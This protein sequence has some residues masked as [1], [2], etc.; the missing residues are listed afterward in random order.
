MSQ[1]NGRVTGLNQDVFKALQQVKNPQQMSSAEAQKLKTAIL[2]DGKIDANE[3]DL[4]EELTA[5]QTQ[6]RVEA[7][8]ESNF[9]P[10]A[11]NFK[12][13]QGEAKTILQTLNQV[14]PTFEDS[15][16]D[17]GIGLKKSIGL[18]ADIAGLFDPT[19]ASDGVSAVISLS[20]GEWLNAGL[21]AG[22]M[23]PYF[24]DALT[25]PALVIRKVA[26]EF[27]GLSRAVKHADDV[28]KLFNTMKALGTSAADYRVVQQSLNTLNNMHKAA[29]AAYASPKIL[30]GAKKWNLPTNGPVPFVPPKRWNPNN[31]AKTADGKGYIDAFGNEWRKGPS[32]TKGEAIEWDVIPKNKSGGLANF[33]RDKSHVNVSMEGVVTHR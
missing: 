26:S 11:L 10:S 17:Q 20:D 2:K 28:P 9:N 8:R 21:S 31:P 24:G 7:R 12:A 15:E 22:A 25:K 29:E 23:F 5:N 18:A 1:I 30:A 33:S 3:Q 4:L 14:G 16:I 32:R 6:V 19:P 27:P 13:T